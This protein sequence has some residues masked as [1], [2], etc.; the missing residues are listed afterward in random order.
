MST[1]TCPHPSAD[2]PAPLPSGL[3][4][5]SA[6]RGPLRP[7]RS[8]RGPLG[9]CRGTA[10]CRAAAGWIAAGDQSPF[11]AGADREIGR[12]AAGRCRVVGRPGRRRCCLTRRRFPGW[13]RWF[14]APLRRGRPGHGRT[15]RCRRGPEPNSRDSSSS[16]ARPGRSARKSGRASSSRARWPGR[17][18]NATKCSCC[19]TART[20]SKSG[21]WVGDELRVPVVLAWELEADLLRVTDRYA[22]AS[23]SLP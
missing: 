1:G 23:R 22:A 2:V 14:E 7:A 17:S 4:R 11:L 3:R 5:G 16:P 15:A 9:G 6:R 19:S 13:D 18:T 10:E 20:T 8:R 21:C 12:D